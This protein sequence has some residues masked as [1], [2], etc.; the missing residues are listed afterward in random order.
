MDVGSPRMAAKETAGDYQERMD[1]MW[2]RYSEVE[3]ELARTREALAANRLSRNW[4][5]WPFVVL[6]LVE[7]YKIFAVANYFIGASQLRAYNLNQTV[8]F[9]YSFLAAVNSGAVV[10]GM[11]FLVS[12][13]AYYYLRGRVK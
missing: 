5:F 8:G 2:R 9:Y 7:M 12:L 6:A 10:V 3:V 13:L 1:E 4:F 11:G